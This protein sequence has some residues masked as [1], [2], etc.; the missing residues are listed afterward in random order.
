MIISRSIFFNSPFLQ[1]TR[2][3]WTNGWKKLYTLAPFLWPK[4]S[5]TLQFRVILCIGLLIAGRVINVIVPIYNQKI[6]NLF[7]THN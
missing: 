2:S 1:D 5:C 7:T 6:G 3:T 4:K